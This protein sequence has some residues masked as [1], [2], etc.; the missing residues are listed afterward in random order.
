MPPSQV[1]VL[2]NQPDQLDILE[3][4]RLCTVFERVDPILERVYTIIER[5]HSV[6]ERVYII[7]ER[8]HPVL[9]QF[10][11]IYERTPAKMKRLTCDFVRSKQDR[12]F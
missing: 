5:L 6:L 7:I 9:E 2:L 10:P 1:L 4:E 3:V 8:L 12:L 11:A